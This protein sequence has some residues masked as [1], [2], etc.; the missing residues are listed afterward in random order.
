MLILRLPHHW[1]SLSL[2]EEEKDD[3]IRWRSSQCPSLGC[4][5]IG[6]ERRPKDRVE[7]NDLSSG[8]CP[9]RSNLIPYITR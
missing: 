6:A 4:L 9:P 5:A 3:G 7:W 2:V 8:D 1:W